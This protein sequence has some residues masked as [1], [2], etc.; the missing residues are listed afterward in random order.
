MPIT[1]Y[2]NNNGLF[3]N[4]TRTLGL[5]KSTGWWNSIQGV[6]LDSDGD[7]DYVLGNLGLNTKFRTSAEQ[8]VRVYVDDFNKDG[9]QD[10]VLSN[11]IQGVNYPAHPRDDIFQQ[12]PQLK[13]IYP[14]YKAY[15][16]ATLND[17]LASTKS[18]HPQ[19]AKAERFESCTVINEGKSGWKV[20]PLPI[21][22]QFAPVFGIV[23][24]DYNGDGFADVVLTGNSYAPDVLTGRYDAMKGLLLL[25]DGTG[26]LKSVRIQRSGILVDGDAKGLAQ[27]ITSDRRIVILAAQSD[28]SLRVMKNTVD[29]NFLPLDDHDSYAIVTHKNG[30]KSRHEF[31]RGSGYLSQSSRLFVLPWDSRRVVIYDFRGEVSG[32]R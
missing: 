24:G 4:F 15:A 18:T 9:K 3:E 16:E 32:D 17:F 10:A 12:M 5:D 22:A 26:S 20:E 30:R 2:K 8:P 21:E 23:A 19:I 31:Y 13:K 28:D 14:D 11:T 7:T 6:D 27:L 29:Q 25:G 1:V